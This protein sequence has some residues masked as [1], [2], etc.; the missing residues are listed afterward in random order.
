MKFYETLIIYNIATMPPQLA[1]ILQQFGQTIMQDLSRNW[2][3]YLYLLKR[4][5]PSYMNDISKKMEQKEKEIQEEQNLAAQSISSKDTSP[6][7]GNEEV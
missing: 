3:H 6:Q 5:I 7:G 2:P 1:Q 4:N